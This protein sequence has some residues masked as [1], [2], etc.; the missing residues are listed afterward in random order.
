MLR[1]RSSTGKR[2]CQDSQWSFSDSAVAKFVGNA[3]LV[4]GDAD[5]YNGNSKAA[6]NL[7]FLIPAELREFL[8][9]E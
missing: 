2:K 8:L 3:F 9:M 7:C 6:E 4:A 1:F 5:I